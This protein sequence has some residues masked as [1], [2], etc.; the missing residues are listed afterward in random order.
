MASQIGWTRW[1]N[2]AAHPKETTARTHKT[3]KTHESE[4]CI[5]HHTTFLDTCSTRVSRASS[6]CNSATVEG[7]KGRAQGRS[8]ALDNHRRFAVNESRMNVLLRLG[9]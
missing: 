9:F 2:F 4:S 1:G 5:I 6:R 7:L 8:A 3:H